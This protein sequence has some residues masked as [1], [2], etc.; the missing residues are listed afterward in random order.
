M[1]G[2]NNEKKQKIQELT[3]RFEDLEQRSQNPNLSQEEFE[4]LQNE[5]TQINQEIDEL[6]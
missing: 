1:F 2:K 4:E 3:K 6:L 5:L